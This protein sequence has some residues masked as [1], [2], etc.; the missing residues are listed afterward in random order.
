MQIVYGVDSLKESICLVSKL[1]KMR[2]RWGDGDEDG[3]IGDRTGN[4]GSD[5]LRQRAYSAAVE[6]KSA[7][8]KKKGYS[9]KICGKKNT[10]CIPFAACGRA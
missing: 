6:K 3:G 9:G 5:K 4:R 1:R 8:G 10:A 2:V 7:P